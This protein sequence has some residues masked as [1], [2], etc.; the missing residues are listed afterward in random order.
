MVRRASNGGATHVRLSTELLIGFDRSQVH[1]VALG[2]ADRVI[3]SAAAS[4][5]GH[6]FTA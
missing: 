1:I 6:S 2:E 4:Y 5:P 3:Q